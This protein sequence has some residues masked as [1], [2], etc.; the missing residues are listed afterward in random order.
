[1]NI[2]EATYICSQNNITVYP[3]NVGKDIYIEYKQNHKI[4]RIDKKVKQGKD[5][6]EAM[7]KTYIFLANKIKK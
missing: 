1:M 2:S 3:V 6:G 7:A 5:V 4:K